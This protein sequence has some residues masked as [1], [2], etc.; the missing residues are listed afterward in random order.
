MEVL[1]NHKKKIGA[2]RKSMDQLLDM[3]QRMLA[4]R[5][6]IAAIPPRK[7]LEDPEGMHILYDEINLLAE[8][9]ISLR[10][11]TLGAVSVETRLR[12][13]QGVESP[14][15][16]ATR[17]KDQPPAKPRKAIPWHS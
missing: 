9:I 13:M 11:S 2:L 6:R 10:E 4:L 8:S 12:I 16:R 17:E 14:A 7:R 1:N 15:T 3:H 5:N